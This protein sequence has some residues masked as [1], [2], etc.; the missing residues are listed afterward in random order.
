MLGNEMH[1]HQ[2]LAVVGFVEVAQMPAKTAS[3]SRLAQNLQQATD[4]FRTIIEGLV[5]AVTDVNVGE[6]YVPEIIRID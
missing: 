1:L 5:D 3:Y 6:S 2:P 4:K